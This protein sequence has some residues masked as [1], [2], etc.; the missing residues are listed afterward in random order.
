MEMHNIQF[1]VTDWKNIPTTEHKGE[2]G[3]ALWRTQHFDSTASP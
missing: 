3:M 2:S 1:S